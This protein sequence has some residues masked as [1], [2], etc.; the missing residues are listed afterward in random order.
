MAL[1]D[2]S[3][4]QLQELLVDDNRLG[5]QGC[6]A[7]AEAGA[8]GA[9]PTLRVLDLYQNGIGNAGLRVLVSACAHEHAQPFDRGEAAQRILGLSRG[10]VDHLRGWWGRWL[11]FGSGLACCRA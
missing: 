4:A 1:A 11:R 10:E 6:A 9:V 2:G 5:D 7:L 3:L 8:L